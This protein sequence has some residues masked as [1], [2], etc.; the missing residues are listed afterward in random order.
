[1]TFDTSLLALVMLL[2]W[3]WPLWSV[4]SFW[5][6]FTFI[7]GTYLSSN[8]NKVAAGAWFSLMLAFI[9]AAITFLWSWGQGL[10]AAYVRGNKILL[11]DLLEE[12]AAGKRTQPRSAGKSSRAARHARPVGL[13]PRALTCLAS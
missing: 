13:A 11:R 12:D 8:M 9:L 5:L 7:T 2:C 6:L 10:K 4:T 3:D 1:M